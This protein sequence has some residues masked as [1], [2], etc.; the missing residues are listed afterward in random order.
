MER[1]GVLVTPAKS[2]LEIPGLDTQL[3]KIKDQH[4]CFVKLQVIQDLNFEE[5]T[6]SISRYIKKKILYKTMISKIMSV[7]RSDIS[8]TAAHKCF[9]GKKFFYV[10][11]LL[12]K[13]RNFQIED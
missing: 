2:S 6:C 10:A 5:D 4:E 3:F 13:S 11:K 7:E 9:S 12:A 1:S 8:P